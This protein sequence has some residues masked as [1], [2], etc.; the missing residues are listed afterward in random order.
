MRGLWLLKGRRN[1]EVASLL[2]EAKGRGVTPTFLPRRTLD[3][4]AGTRD[5]QGVVAQAGPLPLVDLQRLLQEA[6]KAPH[7]LLLFLDGVQDPRNLGALVRSVGAFGGSGVVFTRERTAPPS[8]VAAKAAAGALDHVPLCRVVNLTRALE[9]AKE[10]GFWVLGLDERGKKAM[11]EIALEDP[12]AIVVGGE[13]T[14]LRRLVREGCDYLI[15]IPTLN[16]PSSLNVSVALGIALYE[17]TR[18]R[19]YSQKYSVDKKERG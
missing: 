18:G 16:V 12:L 9:G 17:M 19:K 11:G 2:A 1:Q 10:E 5:H 6:R 15:R 7:P 4:M 8:P 14:G 3:E 13:G